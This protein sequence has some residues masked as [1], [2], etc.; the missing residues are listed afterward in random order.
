M[1]QSLTQFITWAKKLNKFVKIHFMQ[2][3]LEHKNITYANNSKLV[4]TL[5]FTFELKSVQS[6]FWYFGSTIYFNRIASVRFLYQLNRRI[7]FCVYVSCKCYKS[8]SFYSTTQL[9]QEKYVWERPAQFIRYKIITK[10]NFLTRPLKNNSQ[11][12]NY[13]LL[14]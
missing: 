4:Q 13:H 3:K 12:I 14:L 10:I 7:I 1:F 8:L 11:V 2:S 5:W 6:T 9:Q